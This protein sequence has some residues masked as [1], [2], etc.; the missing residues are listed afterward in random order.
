MNTL[1][2]KVLKFLPLLFFLIGLSPL[3]AQKKTP[4]IEWQRTIG[5]SSSDGGRSIQRTRDGGYIIGGISAS[6][7][8][9]DKTVDAKTSIGMDYWVVKIDSAR[10]IQWQKDFGSGLWDYLYSVI[11][12]DDG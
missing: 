11:Q 7:S 4:V 10:N 8:S 5:G 6:D 1:Y 9:A 3:L 2:T 12:S